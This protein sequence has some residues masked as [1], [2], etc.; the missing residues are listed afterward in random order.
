[1]GHGNSGEGAASQPGRAPEGFLE[2]GVLGSSL[3]DKEACVSCKVPHRRH[4]AFLREMGPGLTLSPRLVPFQV[5]RSPPRLCPLSSVS[6]CLGLWTVSVQAQPQ[7]SSTECPWAPDPGVAL[8][9]SQTWR[10]RRQGRGRSLGEPQVSGHFLPSPR[11]IPLKRLAS[12]PSSRGKTRAG[13][14]LPVLAENLN[15]PPPAP[16]LS[17]L[18]PNMDWP[19]LSPR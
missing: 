11:E 5:S 10:W 1:M 2:E 15:K 4:R 16:S 7:G 19:P 13:P 17:L 8:G 14:S 18:I 3:Q 12:G 6:G 9:L